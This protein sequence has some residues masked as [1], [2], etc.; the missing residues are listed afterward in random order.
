MTTTHFTL[1]DHQCAA[2]GASMRVTIALEAVRDQRTAWI[3]G[4]EKGSGAAD[5]KK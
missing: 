2:R 1:I 4:R 5:L 3:G